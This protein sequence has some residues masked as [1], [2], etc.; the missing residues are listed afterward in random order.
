MIIY[1]AALAIAMFFAMNI[2]ASGTA[3]SMG[4]AYGGGALQKRWVALLIVGAAAFAGAIC[5]GGAVVRT[6]GHG[7]VPAQ[8]LTPEL[9]LI[10]LLSACL[11]LF[12]ANLTGIPLSTSEVTVGAVIG[13]GLAF[14][15]MYIERIMFIFAI[16]LLMPVLSFAL[17]FVGWKLLRPLEH[18]LKT[19]I[20]HP[21]LIPGLKLLLLTAG[22][23]EAFSAGM[24]N[25]ANAVGPLVG[26]HMI[27]SFPAI[28]W[29][30]AFVAAGAMLLGGRVLETNAKKITKLSL[31]Q[32]FLVSATSGTLVLIA[33]LMG[34]PVP[35][36]Q[37][38]TTA[39]I[40]VGSSQEG[41]KL[42]KG[43]TVKKIIAVWII[44]PLA[45]LMISFVLV[46]II[47]F[48]NITIGIV[49][50]SVLLLLGFFR[51][52]SGKKT[53]EISFD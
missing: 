12:L 4:A 7:I 40:G 32:G 13:I 11:T 48:S 2:G 26:A 34:L 21:W 23:Y 8:L 50:L 3:A 17:S 37:A 10:I 43:D 52:L 19:R 51:F 44:S 29:G 45:A 31:L 28:L 47:V 38:T 36:T 35:L 53:K 30:G 41:M 49:F 25:V 15:Q 14:Q 42:L 22:V 20:R 16:W 9:T 5:G 33:S 18:A 24:N 6:I 1:V 27:H 39:I 46:Q